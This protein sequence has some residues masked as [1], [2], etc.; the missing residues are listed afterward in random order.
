LNELNK[1][2]RDY[3]KINDLYAAATNYKIEKERQLQRKNVRTL[4]LMQKN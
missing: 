4:Y 1:A 3:V 2:N